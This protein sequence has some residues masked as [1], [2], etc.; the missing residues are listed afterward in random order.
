[1][2]SVAVSLKVESGRIVH[3][4]IAIGGVGAVP[5]RAERLENGLTGERPD[6]AVLAEAMSSLND[7]EC[8]GDIHASV[9]YRRHLL[10]ALTRRA[11][12]RAALQ[13]VGES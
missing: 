4:R 13:A 3:A 11:I 5:Q 7:V 6:E 8:I 2:V 9:Q 1:M 12:N 10:T